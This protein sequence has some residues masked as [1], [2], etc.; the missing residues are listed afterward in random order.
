MRP[1]RVTVTNAASSPVIP[2]DQYL[3]PFNVGLGCDVTGGSPTYTVQYTFDDVWA[4]GFDPATA[5]WFDH[6]SMTAQTGDTNSNI[7]FA[8]TAVRM[9]QTGTGVTTMTVIQAG[10]AA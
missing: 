8:V 2:L 4:T 6:A 5:K 9:T 1:I 7:A 3:T 10:G